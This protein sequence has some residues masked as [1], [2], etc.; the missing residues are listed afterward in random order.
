MTHPPLSTVVPWEL[1]A[2]GF[3][4]FLFLFL[5]PKT[6]LCCPRQICLLSAMLS[7]RR[8]FK[9]TLL[10]EPLRCKNWW[11]LRSDD[12]YY[13]LN[14][15]C[16]LTVRKLSTAKSLPSSMLIGLIGIHILRKTFSRITSLTLKSI[17]LLMSPLSFH[18]Y[19]CMI[20]W[21][22]TSEVHASNIIQS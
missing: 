22:F 18:Y 19:L 15:R 14:R 4:P 20:Y 21:N 2:K 5:I 3:F 12:Y 13:V 1:P 17:Q 16:G 10:D 11:F 9:R 7:F 6:L 8:I